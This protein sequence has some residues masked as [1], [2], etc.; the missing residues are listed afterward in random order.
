MLTLYLQNQG[1]TVTRW[2]QSG[3]GHPY[4]W[5]ECTC[6]SRLAQGHTAD[7]AACL[8]L[9]FAG[10][11]TG[12][13]KQARSYRW[14]AKPEVSMMVQGACTTGIGMS[15]IRSVRARFQRP[16]IL[17]SCMSRAPSRRRPLSGSPIPLPDPHPV[18]SAAVLLSSASL[19]SLRA[20]LGMAGR[21]EMRES[22][23][24]LWAPSR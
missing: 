14:T 24:A 1:P 3:M 22:R 5:Q 9:A 19:C 6:V 11:C 7:S 18:D 20:Q 15:A 23:A 12:E 4:A 17:Q 16:C 10:E 13:A 2:I 8:L 21:V